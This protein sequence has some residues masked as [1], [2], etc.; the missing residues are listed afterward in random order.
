M[1]AAGF[2]A[3]LGNDVVLTDEELAREEL[4]DFG[5]GCSLIHEGNLHDAGT[6]MWLANM[7]DLD[8][9]RERA[10]GSVLGGNE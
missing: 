7:V 10:K 8:W 1:S 6:Y 3:R 9:L 2:V 4:D 5:R